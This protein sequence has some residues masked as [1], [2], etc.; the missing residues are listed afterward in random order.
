MR[1]LL[2]NAKSGSHGPTVLADIVRGA[3]QGD[4]ARDLGLP[5]AVTQVTSLEIRVLGDD[6]TQ[7]IYPLMHMVQSNK[8]TCFTHRPVV[9]PGVHVLKGDPLADGACCD[10]SNLALGKNV[11]VA[12]MPWG[13]YNYEDAILISERLVKDDVYTS[14]H[15]ERHETEAVDTKLGPEEITRDIPNVGEE[16]LKD[17]DENGIIRV[18]A[19]VK[20]IVHHLHVAQAQRLK[21]GLGYAVAPAQGANLDAAA[22]AEVVVDADPPRQV[23]GDRQRT[24]A[25]HLAVSD[26]AHSG[27]SRIFV[28]VVPEA[29]LRIPAGRPRVVSHRRQP[30]TRSLLVF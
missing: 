12:F 14:I 16:A 26:D 30:G 8:S 28:R 29:V 20:A 4:F 21:I 18:G 3:V 24:N 5:G 7:D 27:D 22:A 25:Q 2:P 17:L 15:I 19:E 9:S 23:R 10:Q 11:L 13:G 1:Q 6:G